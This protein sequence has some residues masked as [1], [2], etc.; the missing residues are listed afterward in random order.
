MKFTTTDLRSLNFK[1]P[2]IYRRYASFLV[3]TVEALKNL[4][5]IDV[6]S[7]KCKF[8]NLKVWKKS[9]QIDEFRMHALKKRS[10]KKM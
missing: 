5:A 9:L 10:A 2:Y 7:L 3:E 1:K 6:G 4:A 8:D